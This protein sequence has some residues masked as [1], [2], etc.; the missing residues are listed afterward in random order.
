MNPNKKSY[1]LFPMPNFTSTL[2]LIHRAS[3]NH[4]QGYTLTIIEAFVKLVAAYSQI[5]KRVFPSF[6]SSEKDSYL[7][8]RKP[9]MTTS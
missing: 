6:V 1:L 8:S 9:C 5:L 4:C 7:A 2:G 3:S